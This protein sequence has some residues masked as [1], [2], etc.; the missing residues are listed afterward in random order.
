MTSNEMKEIVLADGSMIHLNANS[1]F[2][3]PL[4]FNQD[5]REVQLKGE[6]FFEVAKDKNHPFIIHT[7]YEDVTVLGTS[8][9]VRAYPNEGASEISVS[10]GKVSVTNGLNEQIL[11]PNQKAIV[12]RDSK[13]IIFETSAS[14]NE[15]AWHTGTISFTDAMVPEVFSDLEDYYNIHFNYDKS[16]LKNCHFTSTFVNEDLS[17]VLV[18]ISTVLNVSIEPQENDTYLLVGGGCQ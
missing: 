9:N 14:L 4:S 12:T 1:S 8:F 6:G 15:T 3:Y 13:K 10:K 18:T 16:K 11:L 2:T 7:G 17:T 5:K